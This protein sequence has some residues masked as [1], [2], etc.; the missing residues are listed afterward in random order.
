MNEELKS[1][2]QILEE[3]RSQGSAN[4]GLEKMTPNTGKM[5]VGKVKD[6]VYDVPTSAIY[7]RLSDGSFF[8]R[9]EN[10][11]GAVGN[12]DRLAKNQT[13]YEQAGY[14]LLKNIRKAGNYAIDAT[15]GTV[16]GVLSAVGNADFEKLYDN[17]FSNTLDD[18]NKQLDYKLPNYY[19]DEEKSQGFFKNMLTSN[20]WFNDVAG[21]LAFVAGALAPEA[22]KAFF[23]GGAS[24]PLALSRFAAKSAF[25]SGDDLAKLALR[26]GAEQSAKIPGILG[27]GVNVVD[28]FNDF[29]TFEKGT[30]ALRA[31]Q[32]ANFTKTTADYL[33]TGLF[34][35]RTSNFEAGMEARHNFKDAMSQYFETF[36]DKN[37]RQPTFEEISSFTDQARSASNGVY[38]AN[39]GILTL[40]NAAMFG[41]IAGLGAKTSR[42]SRNPFNKALGLGIEKKAGGELALSG[43]NR[44]QRL[45]GNTYKLLSKPLIEGV[46]EEG[47]QG[48][49][50][51]TMQNYLEAKYDPDQQ[52]GFSAWAALTDAFAE[53]YGTKEGWKEMGIGFI[54]GFAGGAMQGEGFAGIGKNSRKSAEIKLGQEVDQVNR[55]VDVLRNVNRASTMR[56]FRNSIES[57]VSEY[58]STSAENAMMNIE[59][60]KS[61]EH[62][63]SKQEIQTDFDTI[64]DNMD[65]DEQSIDE[66]GSENID[67]YKSSLKE[68]FSR[69][70]NNYK[71]AKKTI[72]SLGLDKYVQ[73]G[74]NFHEVS[75]ALTMQIVIGKDALESAKN[76]A[77]QIGSLI[78]NDGV[79]DY[80]QFYN[81]L[82]TQKQESVAQVRDKRRRVQNLQKL[83]IEYGQRAAGAQIQGRRNFKEGTLNKRLIENSEKLVLVQQQ[84]TQLQNDIENITQSLNNDLRTSNYDLDG[85][86]IS[87]RLGV[88]DVSMAID[89]LD[90]LDSYKNSLR[91]NDREYEADSIDYLIKQFKIFSDTHRE[92]NNTTRR[93]ISTDF[94]STQEGSSM[95]DSII[96][97]KYKMSDDFIQVLKD[98]DEVIDKSLGATGQARGVKTVEEYVKGAL[99]ENPEMSE[100]EKFNLESILRLQLGVQD[101]QKQLDTLTQ[102]NTEISS[103]KESTSSPLQ[104]D[105]VVLKEKLDIEDMNFNNI[106]VIDQTI[107]KIMNQVDYLR[108][109]ISREEGEKRISELT[110]AKE[111]IQSIEQEYQDGDYIS[112]G[113]LAN[114]IRNGEE[115][116]TDNEIQLA[117][118]YPLLLEV[119][120]TDD[121]LGKILRKEIQDYA[122][123]TDQF[124]KQLKN[125][126]RRKSENLRTLPEYD[127][128]KEIGDRILNSGFEA[129]TLYSI[130][131]VEEL[132]Y[133]P[134]STKQSILVYESIAD[135][136]KESKVKVQFVRLDAETSKKAAGFYST[137]TGVVSTNFNN[138]GTDFLSIHLVH[139]LVHS[140][141]SD[142]IDAF[143]NKPESL[144]KS[145]RNAVEDLNEIIDSLQKNKY[146]K[147]EYGI[148]NIHEL[149]AE[150]S[151]KEFTDKLKVT[152]VKPG[153]TLFQVVKEGFMTIFGIPNS[154]NSYERVFNALINISKDHTSE[155]YTQRYLSDNV[156][157]NRDKN[158]KELVNAYPEDLITKAVRGTEEVADK[159][160][161][162][163]REF[164]EKNNAE[165]NRASE[166]ILNNQPIPLSKESILNKLDDEIEK[167]ISKA[168]DIKIIN[169]QEY[170]DLYE[171]TKKDETEGLTQQESEE[172]EELKDSINQWLLIAGTVADGLRL[173]DLIR[174]KVIL[175]ET[176]I[177]PVQEVTNVNPQDILDGVDFG[178]RTGNAN[179]SLGQSYD[180]VTA[181]GDSKTGNI[182]VSGITPEALAEEVGFDFEYTT[183]ERGNILLTPEVVA[184]IN[185][186]STI[187][188][189]PTN[190]DLATN[191]SIVIKHGEDMNGN[192]RSFP[193]RSN[194]SEDF[195]E[196]QNT[197]A[198]YSQNPGDILILEVSPEDEY[199]IELLNSYRSAAGSEN[200]SEEE[201][202][203]KAVRLADEYVKND[204]SLNSM[205]IELS[206]LKEQVKSAPT[207][208]VKVEL[209]KRIK[210]LDTKIGKREDSLIDKAEVDAYK[211][212]PRNQAKMDAAIEDLKKS[213]VIRVKDTQGNFLAVLKAK[214][215]GVK[216]REDLKFD[217]LRNQIF[218]DPDLLNQV[219]GLNLSEEIEI[220]NLVVKKIF[221][222]HPNFNFL[223]N[224]DGSVGIAYKRITKQDLSK[225]TDIGFVENGGLNTRTKAS[226]IDTTFLNKFIKRSSGNEKIPFIVF[227]KEN[228]RVG[229][230]VRVDELP[231]KDNKEFT[232]VYNSSTS[233]LNK[234][235]ALNRIL[236][237]R[238]IDIKQP[239]N[240]FITFGESN[241]NDEF[242]NQKLRQLEEMQYY[243]DLNSW[244]DPQADIASILTQ[245]ASINIDL[246]NPLHSP[247]VQMDFD[248][249]EV[250]IT[251]EP[252]I[253]DKK[254]RAKKETPSKSAIHSILGRE[255]QESAEDELNEDC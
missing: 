212:S 139:E 189:L 51:R 73:T 14:G 200:L 47:L 163:I 61:Q 140:I 238:G 156:I 29:N 89:E 243:Y 117:N 233:D 88:Q 19:S 41:K 48:V 83:A 94:F 244:L 39:L 247:K 124:Q 151:N 134:G 141:T 126:D 98:N 93:M 221:I 23:S 18:W 20:F 79:F 252:Q 232:D 215:D 127:E 135:K 85:S 118:N 111:R 112:V 62:L 216:S 199:N 159:R 87:N 219:A 120:I 213:A 68:E 38:A 75:E 64:V 66:I 110:T 114:K 58:K 150:L 253:E 37:G 56:N 143:K 248:N 198:I 13:W 16:Y 25:K 205:K 237:S 128:I 155:S 146:F 49:A 186:E 211:P 167:V 10:Y 181:I 220:P 170:L 178:D 208:A 147:G 8:P 129:N 57:G 171:L 242:F 113:N 116:T 168:R 7:D 152:N 241:L 59:F 142:A 245:Q 46:Y 179:Y 132:I 30:N 50:G 177:E 234:A 15:L 96:G 60:I 78:G 154:N 26:E 69:N 104:G 250:E 169:S 148:T 74:G 105:T 121:N 84:I 182:A 209:N 225:I 43:A 109:T 162:E 108:S 185:A 203:D 22:V 224:T 99:E 123:K 100:R 218:S 53:Q 130:E 2:D 5:D 222:G 240:A 21:G 115:A 95:I 131:D 42:L 165:Y 158:L 255:T 195:A 229:Y 44:L 34:L 67:Q 82:D 164:I 32:R 190:K 9:F 27:S 106:E 103:E 210:S 235:A 194:Y 153:R 71:F 54:I 217:A 145:Q 161:S 81:G 188:I 1:M 63:K 11:A 45:T 6:I 86:L 31:F 231:A 157:Q 137:T 101:L 160:S 149:L 119:L 192:P 201:L 228:V 214:N 33:K 191:Y 90:K 35:A 122:K 65:L 36:E 246:S 236:A 193:L 227:D 184:Q 183:N 3:L 12:E 76:V 125:I 166:N 97:K 144:T 40:S 172:M 197:D 77:G 4:Q 173:S 254:S 251:E 176:P 249:I 207:T 226:G 133:G 196:N 138:L 223:K 52:S 80:M 92:L 187:S 180:A 28:K 91:Q 136:L 174:Q 204:V 24:V 230:P 175:E 70:L 206:D 102:V 72:S 17:D 55:G 107:K 239:G 202:N